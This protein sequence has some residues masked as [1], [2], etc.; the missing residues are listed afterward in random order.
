MRRVDGPV[1]SMDVIIL[2]GKMV[3]KKIL[4]VFALLVALSSIAFADT[5]D[6]SWTGRLDYVSGSASQENAAALSQS[7]IAVSVIAN[8]LNDNLWNWEYTIT[9]ENGADGIHIFTLN[10]SDDQLS[11][12]DNSS[13]SN[14]VSWEQYKS[15]YGVSWSTGNQADVLGSGK[16][17]TFSFESTLAPATISL[18][19]SQDGAQYN[20]SVPTPAVPEPMS[21]MLGIMGLGSIA[22]LKKFRLN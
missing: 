3:M 14:N 12:I 17:G 9:P 8:K 22:G 19:T 1:G 6:F 2:W 15:S 7:W 21:I 20:G 13:I 16:S 5:P 10:L 18:A 11:T 4:F